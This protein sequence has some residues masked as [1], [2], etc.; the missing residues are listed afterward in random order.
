LWTGQISAE[1]ISQ[2]PNAPYADDYK[3]LMATALPIAS[4]TR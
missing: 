4:D 2:G 3:A 1:V